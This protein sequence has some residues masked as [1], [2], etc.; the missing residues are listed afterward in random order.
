MAK[1]KAYDTDAA[2]RINLENLISIFRGLGA[3]KLYAK[4][5]APND[6]SK[7]QPYLGGHLTD[8]AFIPTGE[9][10]PSDTTSTKSKDPKRKIKYQVPTDFSWVDAEGKVYDA[11]NT[12]L[13]YYPQYP[14]VRLSGF[15][16]GSQVDASEWM[17]RY[18]KGT[19][20]GRWLII[21][22][23]KTKKVFAYLVTPECQLSRE[24][25]NTNF[26]DIGSVFGQIDIEGIGVA[27]TRAAL[28]AKLLDIHYMGWVPGQRLKG[29]GSRISYKAANGGGYTLESLLDIIPNGISE[30]DYLGWE[31]KQFGVSAFPQKGPK[32]TT[33]LTPEPDGG[34]YRA[35]GAAEFVRAFGYPDKSGK[36]D[37]LN[38]GG[39]HFARTQC[40]ATN[41]ILHVDGFD[42]EAGQITD[43]S[44]AITLRNEEGML[45]ASWSFAKIMG[46]WKR[47]H[48]QAV[49][50]PCMMRSAGTGREYHYGNQVEL[51][52]G[53]DFEMLLH[54]TLKRAV[55]YDPGIKLE[56]A[57]TDKAKLKLRSQF[58][59]NHRDLRT[60]YT[61]M[62]VIDLI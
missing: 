25:G 39:R 29:D 57:S 44:G 32:P 47:K 43:A 40:A 61:D 8:L 24:L 59:A 5:L 60:L 37:R 22:V 48:A 16:K 54:A 17:D 35:H 1:Y 36:P 53:T 50:V 33:L 31:V 52:I 34:F 27:D 3:I 30:P 42:E 19:S 15:L 10:V 23:T 45:A 62:H 58:R 26:L 21:G 55:Y 7:N 2:K 38:F 12:K 28:Q 6:N 56:N 9:P 41:L 18:K 49:Y 51:G 14:E 4:S 20:L 11:P 46:H 13:I